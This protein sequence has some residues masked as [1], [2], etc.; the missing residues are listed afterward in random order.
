MAEHYTRC[1]GCGSDGNDLPVYRCENNHQF[2][3]D[4]A[5]A[6]SQANLI[7]PL[8]LFSSKN[9]CPQCHSGLWEKAGNIMKYEFPGGAHGH[10][11]AIGG[12]FMVGSDCRGANS[13]CFYFILGSIA[14]LGVAAGALVLMDSV[15]KF[16]LGWWL[17]CF[18]VVGGIPLY[19]ALAYI[20]WYASLALAVI[21]GVVQIAGQFPLLL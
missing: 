11:A 18:A 20:T 6:V 14:Y 9:I 5:G 13:A 10:R 8:G 3:P 15:E 19:I 12:T 1:P 4:C 7:D 16:S 21:W 2:C 17:C